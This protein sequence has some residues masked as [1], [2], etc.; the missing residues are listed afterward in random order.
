[1]K[2]YADHSE[3]RTLG[4]DRSSSPPPAAAKPRRRRRRTQ[5]E[6]SAETRALLLDVTIEC[7]G[8]LGYAGATAQVIAERAGLSRGAQLH[9]FGTKMALVTQ[10]ME[11]LFERRLAEFRSG[12]AELPRDTSLL[13][14]SIDLLWSMVSGPA[15][16]AY[17][18]L[19]IASRTDQRLNEAMVAVTKRMDEQVE[20]AIDDLY[21]PSHGS[22]EMLDIGWTALFSLMEGVALEK[23]VRPDDQRLDQVIVLLKQLAPTLMNPR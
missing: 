11:H 13:S 4:F 15:G 22:K 12:F 9:H 23:I 16:H 10:A 7:L 8:E 5:K 20:K 3:P 2:T 6:R 1:M 17:L 14:A 21:E 18:E 19:V